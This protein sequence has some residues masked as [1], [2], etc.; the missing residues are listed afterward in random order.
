MD[1]PFPTWVLW[2]GAAMVAAAIALAVIVGLLRR[3]RRVVL[4]DLERVSPT[5]GRTTKPVAF[6]PAPTAMAAEPAVVDNRL[7]YRRPGNQ[8]GRAS[9]RE[10]V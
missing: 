6:M 9:C 4:R 5:T 3:G 1:R 2:L 10:R 8:I 7:A